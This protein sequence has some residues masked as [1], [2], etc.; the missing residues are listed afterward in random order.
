MSNNNLN[1]SFLRPDDV[2]NVSQIKQG[3]EIQNQYKVNYMD[4]PEQNDI[5]VWG[6][7]NTKN[8]NDFIELEEDHQ[9]QVKGRTNLTWSQIKYNNKNLRFEPKKIHEL[10]WRNKYPDWPFKRIKSLTNSGKRR[11]GAN[12]EI[13]QG[14][15]IDP[16][17]RKRLN[18][19]IAYYQKALKDF[20][21]SVN[22]R[23]ETQVFNIKKGDISGAIVP[24]TIDN[25]KNAQ[26]KQLREMANW[27]YLKNTKD[28][29]HG[30]KQ[31][32]WLDSNS[33]ITDHWNFLSSGYLQNTQIALTG[34]GNRHGV[35]LNNSVL[36]N[37]KIVGDGQAVLLNTYL[38]NSKIEGPYTKA[39]FE[40]SNINQSTFKGPNM[41]RDTDMY[42]FDNFNNNINESSLSGYNQ[43]SITNSNLT[44]V[45]AMSDK[46]NK[47][48]FNNADLKFTK[49]KPY[50]SIIKNNVQKVKNTKDFD[51]PFNL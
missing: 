29:Y 50:V 26:E 49:E 24:S 23:N 15:I 18:T 39:W 25:E 16:D 35:T 33:S 44:D 17:L 40:D 14:Q 20:S 11:Q 38:Q 41:I 3:H 31:N 1:K 42:G 13:V 6:L 30:L 5:R 21:V 2:I 27:R 47:V 34:K 9:N 43:S 28:N 8:P 12:Y 22:P 48:Q 45:I 7:Q 51:D 19:K 32:F 4:F 46:Q 10:I 37:V 36:S